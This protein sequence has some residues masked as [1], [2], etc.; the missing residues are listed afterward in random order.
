MGAT[1]LGW[2]KAQPGVS[3]VNTTRIEWTAAAFGIA[4]ALMLAWPGP[5]SPWGW[6]AFLASNCG[7][8]VFGIYHNLPGL[9][10][11]QFAFSATSLLGIVNH[12]VKP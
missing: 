9:L 5:W 4:G 1:V 8:I 12:L 11:Q 7:W 2:L 6:V 10:L 3:Q